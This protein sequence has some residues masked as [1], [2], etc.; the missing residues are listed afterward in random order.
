M[1]VSVRGFL[2][3]WLPV[4]VLGCASG[5]ETRKEW[6]NVSGPT[7][8]QQFGKDKHE[9]SREVGPYFGIGLGGLLWAQSTRDDAIETCLAG[10]GWERRRVPKGTGIDD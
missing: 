5:P 6:F 10:R 1:R 9:C 2:A 7:T 4:V 8:R 3:M